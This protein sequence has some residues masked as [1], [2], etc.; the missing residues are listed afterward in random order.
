MLELYDDRVKQVVPNTGALV[1]DIV[2][3]AEEKN[4]R[5]RTHL[6]RTIDS[7]AESQFRLQMNRFCAFFCGCL[8]VL[9]I[10]VLLEFFVLDTDE[11][12]KVTAARELHDAACRYLKVSQE[13]LFEK[14]QKDNLTPASGL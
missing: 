1:E 5:L 8:F 12:E 11:S 14:I 10:L 3:D 13:S 2:R 4:F 9:V 6:H 7:E